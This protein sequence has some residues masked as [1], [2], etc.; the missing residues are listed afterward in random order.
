MIVE[1]EITEGVIEEKIEDNSGE[2][3][4]E[5]IEQTPIEETPTE[6]VI[7]KKP[8]N[9][10]EAEIIEEISEEESDI[11]A[12]DNM[13][14]ITETTNDEDVEM[15]QTES[16][17][18]PDSF[19]GVLNYHS[20][21]REGYTQSV[22]ESAKGEVEANY[23]INLPESYVNP[24]LQK[25]RN[26]NPYGTCWAHSSMALA[27]AS[28]VSQGFDVA[29]SID[30]SELQLAYFT[31]NTVT[32][33]LGGTAGDS[34]TNIGSDFMD[35]G[36]NLMFSENILAG[37]VG[38]ASESEVP[39][40]GAAAALSS[41][42][43]SSKA[44]SAAAHLRNYYE[45][46]K[47][48]RDKIKE[49]I[50]K[51]GA[52]GAS[53][54][55][56]M[57]YYNK[58]NNCYYNNSDTTTNHAISIVGWDDEFPAANFKHKA[59]G[60]GAW[61][62]RNSWTTKSDEQSIYGY[63]W[64]SYF[65]S[66]LNGTFYSFKFD[67]ASKYDNN[68]Q[69]DGG[70]YT[71]T[72]SGA[73]NEE[74][75]VANAFV[76]KSDGETLE[77]V[78]FYTSNT[79][80]DYKIRIYSG[81]EPR[82]DRLIAAPTVGKT[83]FA[84]YYTIDLNEKVVLPYSGDKFCVEVSLYKAG[85]ES[86][87]GYEGTSTGS[88]YKTIAVA[89]PGESL[90]YKNGAWEDFANY[91][92][93]GGNLR[94]KAFTTNA[95]APVIVKPS[96]VKISGV[97]PAEGI[98]LGR[99]ESYQARASVL[100]INVSDRELIWESQDE[101]IATVDERTGLVTG[102]SAGSTLI[103]IK[104]KADTT[105][106]ASFKVTVVDGL[107]SIELDDIPSRSIAGA[108]VLYRLE[109][110]KANFRTIP[111][112]AAYD[113]NDVTW[114]SSD[115]TV[116]TVD[117]TGNIEAVGVGK[118]NISVEIGGITSNSIQITVKAA[119]I[120][121]ELALKADNSI[122]VMWK[123]NPED[124]KYTIEAQE[125]GLQTWDT[126]EDDF[127][128]NSSKKYEYT[129]DKY[130]GSTLS[131]P[132]K[133]Y[134]IVEPV[135]LIGGRE[136]TSGG[137]STGIYVGPAT[138]IHQITYDANGGTIDGAPTWI[139]T[140]LK[141]G[142]YGYMPTPVKKGYRFKGW[143]LSKT[144]LS[145]VTSRTFV[146]STKDFAVYAQWEPIKYTIAYDGNGATGGFMDTVLTEAQYDRGVKLADS[147]L[148]RDNYDFAGWNTSPDRTGKAYAN[149]AEVTNLTDVD[150]DIVTLYAQ[151]N[152]MPNMYT[153]TLDTQGGELEAGVLDTI[154][155]R[156]NG[157]YNKLPNPSKDG[158]DFAGWY[159][160]PSAGS[161]VENDTQC[162]V[163]SDHT[164]YAHYNPHRYTVYYD[165]NGATSGSVVSSN[166][167]Y[168]VDFTLPA[169][170]FVKT[171][172]TFM[173][174]SLTEGG[175]TSYAPGTSLGRL[176]AED[177]SNVI[178][179][180][181]WKPNKYTIEFN[182]NGEEAGSTGPAQAEYGS[183]VTLSENGF[184]RTGYKFSKWNT[185]ADGSGASYNDKASVKNLTTLDNETV[186]LYAQWVPIKYSIKYNGNGAT[187][188]TM[189]DTVADY[190]IDFSLRPNSFRKKGYNFAG[191]S[192]SE[193]EASIAYAN[194]E[195]IAAN[196]S[197]TDGDIINLYAQWTPITYSISYNG[198]GATA[199]S[200]SDTAATFKVPV[201]LRSN[202][203]SRTGYTFAGWSKESGKQTVLY[204]DNATVSDDLAYDQDEVVILYA[205]WNPISYKIKY[206]ANSDAT[207]SMADT[208]CVYDATITLP[209]N[210][211]TKTGYLFA[212]WTTVSGEAEAE[213]LDKALIN[214]NLASDEGAIVDLY[215]QFKPLKYKISYNAN[216]EVYTGSVGDSAAV[217]DE[218][219]TLSANSFA[220][221]GY[222]FA[223]WSRTEGKQEVNY[224]DGEDVVN[225]TTIPN[226]T[227]MLYAQW[228][229]NTYY[230]SYNDNTVGATGIMENTECSYDS[231]INLRQNVF[232][233]TG[234]IFMGWS[235]LAGESPIV[236]FD[237]ATI[238]NLAT[239][240]GDVVPLYAQWAPV[241]YSLKFNGNGAT[242]G[243]MDN[244]RVTYDEGIVLNGNAFSRTGYTFAG[245]S[246][247]PGVGSV[248]YADCA[249]VTDNL[250]TVHGSV[251]NLYAQWRPITYRLH[252]DGNGATSGRMEDVIMTYGIAHT[253]SANSFKRIDYEFMG[254]STLQDAKYAQYIDG[255]SVNN[256][257]ARDGATAI[258]YAVWRDPNEPLDPPLDPTEDDNDDDKKDEPT[259]ITTT[260]QFGSG[261]Q[262]GSEVTFD[263][264]GGTVIPTPYVMNANNTKAKLIKPE[265]EGFTFKNWTADGKKVTTLN[266]K[267]LASGK[268]SLKAL[269][270]ENVYTVTYKLTK[271]VQGVKFNKKVK[272]MKYKYTDKVY[273]PDGI[274]AVDKSGN[275]FVLKGW[276]TTP[277]GTVEY[278]SKDKDVS[279]L[280][281]K[282]KKDK[283]VTLYSVWELE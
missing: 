182:G 253:L 31:Y 133:I 206:H 271:P 208:T 244:Q 257:I 198:N 267:L 241:R 113:E 5:I 48:D 140:V 245:W 270:V 42:I 268:L 20:I 199:G 190:G 88:W 131:S 124:V 38:A 173:G 51:N 160:D 134:I 127:P 52:V 33:P 103:V 54:K 141:G 130:V 12:D 99:E 234:Y 129:Y 61:L 197:S 207:G 120:T 36:G 16:E 148:I 108:N 7:I 278:T 32:D 230:I 196:L 14:E 117:S 92:G 237:K 166:Q 55:H 35:I 110:H 157:K 26:Q 273:F 183:Y 29:S 40:S 170:A 68:Y 62:V 215:A 280:A 106:Q 220:R 155:V 251:V 211:F 138:D 17:D 235:D 30:Y 255:A 80:V 145:L 136:Y 91:N 174:W 250:S 274:T 66:S 57:D 21:P 210:G 81:A 28:M 76:T 111:S 94:I 72:S 18:Y 164:L 218:T 44:Y 265:K 135:T 159:T 169:N 214:E 209:Q 223:G 163:N 277:G 279:K 254:W 96:S 19:E 23:L 25:L 150:G 11:L 201:T 149:M 146:T 59:P 70:F 126:L 212:G 172:Y 128:I 147:T 263:F 184:T 90:I 154:K 225:L 281:G 116:A 192:T 232:E 151:W 27:E 226:D 161:K 189:S 64:M 194:E 67:P 179:Y 10:S 216:T 205:Q 109:Q 123:G 3:I 200:M 82:D 247:T 282:T 89:N 156:E 4:E 49:L 283:K 34:N 85:V 9:D 6:K 162:V 84:G 46:S 221:T 75:R 256:L 167:I 43:D 142:I 98:T 137:T 101:S 8:A 107:S 248:E 266:E 217:Y 118:T 168:D 195:V 186:T 15:A 47:G 222:A 246:T 73:L 177:N 224:A 2:I 187:S 249:R 95:K 58:A 74:L 269:Y 202:S 171:G 227:V 258:L 132:K 242:S 153:V 100:P 115:P 60:D 231:D 121:C 119:L 264:D 144:T 276:S 188:G 229:P 71:R 41:G 252:F 272:S 93:G 143:S 238:K 50:M 63:F 112:N 275:T 79:N 240:E 236:Y 65:D 158:Y 243:R 53:Y 175:Q 97:I 102:V 24:N 77:A 180:A 259:V 193:G 87:I 260:L 233:K 39:Y 13:A 125:D 191:W 37:W 203:F 204:A 139:G 185:K 105:K 69:Y 178:I 181:I 122:K 104:A 45:I 239:E 1:E 228:T 261:E 152:L 165:G 56:N 83:T 176:S 262:G 219:V 78:S 22:Y 86:T 114:I 213:F